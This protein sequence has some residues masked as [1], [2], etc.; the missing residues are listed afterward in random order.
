MRV[1]GK[2]VVVGIPEKRVKGE[3]GS[4]RR[5]GRCNVVIEGSVHVLRQDIPVAT[6]SELR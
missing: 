4:H 3:T 6:S 2:E 5:I 1:L